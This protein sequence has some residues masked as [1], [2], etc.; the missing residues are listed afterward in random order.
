MD[1]II[2]N[3]LKR[4]RP[5][6]EAALFSNDLAKSAPKLIKMPHCFIFLVKNGPRFCT[7]VTLYSISR[8]LKN[9]RQMLSQHSTWQLWKFLICFEKF[10]GTHLS[11]QKVHLFLTNLIPFLYCQ[12][13][14][15][16]KRLSAKICNKKVIT[17]NNKL[18]ILWHCFV[19]FKLKQ[20]EKWQCSFFIGKNG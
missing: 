7:L 1:F 3:D 12:N 10:E 6:L 18:Q 17:R 11:K 4:S 16:W 13:C 2:T 5:R 9:N 8:Q 20:T 15:E 19:T 14:Y